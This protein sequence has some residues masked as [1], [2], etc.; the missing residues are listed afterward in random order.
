MPV[1][2]YKLITETSM[3]PKNNARIKCVSLY[4]PVYDYFLHD[5][6]QGIWR[7]KRVIEPGTPVNEFTEIYF[8]RNDPEYAKEKG[9]LLEFEFKSKDLIG[10]PFLLIPKGDMLFGYDAPGII[11]KPN[12][13]LTKPGPFNQG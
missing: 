11:V 8:T 1:K 6:K 2:Y 12:I 9:L 4:A 7:G 3:E 5:K 10:F 13:V